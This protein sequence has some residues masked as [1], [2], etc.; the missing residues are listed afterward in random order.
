MTSDF[1]AER[2]GHAN[3]RE[4]RELDIPQSLIKIVD[5]GAPDNYINLRR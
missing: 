1:V 2:F 4:I 5:L 3:F